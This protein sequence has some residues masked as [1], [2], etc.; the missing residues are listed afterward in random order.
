VLV[1]P[2]IAALRGLAPFARTHP[3]AHGLVGW[4]PFGEGAGTI[5]EDF[6]GYGHHGTLTNMT[7]SSAWAD[8]PQGTQLVFDGS[9]DFVLV[10]NT[11][12]L[13]LENTDAFTIMA[14]IKK[15]AVAGNDAILQKN[16]TVHPYQGFSFV[17][18]SSGKLRLELI[19]NVDLNAIFIDGSGA[20]TSVDD[21]ILH[22]VAATYTGSST[23]AGVDLWVDGVAQPK[24]VNQD[25]LSASIQNTIACNIGRWP[26][27]DDYYVGGMSEIRLYRYRTFSRQELLTFVQAPFLEYQEALASIRRVWAFQGAAAQADAITEG[28]LTG[29]AVTALAALVASLTEGARAGE[30]WATTLLAQATLAEGA[31]TGETFAAL[32]TRPA[33]L[34]EGGTAGDALAALAALL[35][36][37]LEGAL[38]GETLTALARLR[39][40]LAEGATA[41]DAL[42]ALMAAQATLAD[43]AIAGD[44][45]AFLGAAQA[46]ITEGALAGET[47]A[48]LAQ[49]LATVA[50]GATAGETLAGL[51]HALAQFTEGA[52]AGESFVG[53]V[54]GALVGAITG[55]SRAGENFAVAL[56]A[57]ATAIEGAVA[58]EAFAGVAVR[59]SAIIDG[60]LAGDT[61]QEALTRSGIVSEGA[62]AGDIITTVARRKPL[63]TE[64]VLAG[65]TWQG[66]YHGQATWIEGSRAGDTFSFPTEVGLVLGAI[67]FS[68]A[69]AGTL[70]SRPAVSGT[71]R[72]N[73]EEVQ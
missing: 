25:N 48:A 21:N 31:L 18:Q 9:D 23:A 59:F 58:G 11:T 39:A 12:L 55:G 45:F 30:T 40:T 29:D 68:A 14:W 13:T 32:L 61:W 51:M 72:I 69:V 4:W 22:H 24:T 17:V 42:A 73:Q 35:A 19:N 5:A 67:T 70:Q 28:A 44:V 37:V 53:V 10:P 43:G 56:T 16:Q 46:A 15:T 41:G 7:L 65:D 50:E 49:L 3:R 1:K 6:S 34:T 57:F 60:I 64:G 2:P 52:T 54:G 33:T 71:L 63:F 27:G 36:T 62:Q 20:S 8:G 26:G 47:I 38:A 66:L